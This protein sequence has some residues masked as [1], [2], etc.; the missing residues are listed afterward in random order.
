MAIVGSGPAGLECAVELLKAGFE[1]DIIE[2][3]SKS[4]GILTYGIPDFRLPKE[5]VQTIV[6]KI[7]KL[8]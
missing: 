7:I 6:Y 1:V 8:R 2:K 5:I 4:G 3:D